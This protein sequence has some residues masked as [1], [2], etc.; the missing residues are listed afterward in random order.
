MTNAIT[1]YYGSDGLTGLA[2]HPGGITTTG[3]W[4]TL[5]FAEL[6]AMGDAEAMARSFKS[7][8]QGAATTVWAAVSPRFEDVAK[9]GVL[10]GDVGEARAAKEDDAA[11]TPSFAPWAYDV[12]GEDR[13]WKISREMIG[14]G[15]E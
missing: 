11:D 5:S 15:A 13:L 7:A 12:E 8:E 10:L 4:K 6:Q 14:L 9:G 3:L 2:V 1:R